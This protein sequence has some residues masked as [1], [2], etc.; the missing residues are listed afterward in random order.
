MASAT[1]AQ[2]LRSL[3]KFQMAN[4][5][6]GK[7]LL[8]TGSIGVAD[9]LKSFIATKLPT[10]SFQPAQVRLVLGLGLSWALVNV[11]MLKDVLG[12]DIAQ[13]ASLGIAAD[14]LNDYYQIGNRLTNFV[15]RILIGPNSTPLPTTPQ[16][17]PLPLMPPT[18]SSRAQHVPNDMFTR[19]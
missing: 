18:G 6:V 14:A 5:A 12:P 16:T 19:I 17:K 8:L 7:S 9:A 3:A 11:K 4:V 15:N 10:T 2:P 1:V 13:L